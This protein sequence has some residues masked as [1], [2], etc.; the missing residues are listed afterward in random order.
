MLVRLRK[1]I[2]TSLL[3]HFLGLLVFTL[4]FFST[5]HEFLHNH[6]P[7]L[8]EH[9]DCP[10]HQIEILIS[11]SIISFYIFPSVFFFILFLSIPSFFY[12]DTPVYCI[13]NPRAPPFLF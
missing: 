12:I 10:A 11:S 6:A 8:K 9:S 2:Q 4:F 5:A 7:D 1:N 13:C 3:L